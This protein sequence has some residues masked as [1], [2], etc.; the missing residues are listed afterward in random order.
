MEVDRHLLQG[1]F[2]AFQPGEFVK[3]GNQALKC[4]GAVFN[5]RQIFPPL[6]LGQSGIFQQLQVAQ[7]G[8]KRGAQVV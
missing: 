2:P 5:D 8:G 6:L 7:N 3:A 4:F 1:V